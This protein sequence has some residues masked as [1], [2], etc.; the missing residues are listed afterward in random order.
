MK[1]ALT[2]IA[3]AAFLA[4]YIY[5]IRPYLKTLPSLA[6]AWK[7]EETA[8]QAFK[9][10][11]D[12]RKTILAGLWGEF[13]AFFPDLLQI[14]SGVDL[15][16]LLHLPEQWALWVGGIIVPALMAIFRARAR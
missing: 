10:Y 4:A 2:F 3:G 6:E 16:Q 7:A 12:G 15:K 14:V 5:W 11:I 8:W 13:L 1:L 9:T